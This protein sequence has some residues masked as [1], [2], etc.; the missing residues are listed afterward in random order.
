MSIVASRYLRGTPRLFMLL[1]S[2]FCFYWT[3]G[4]RALPL[5]AAVVAASWVGGR[6]VSGRHGTHLLAVGVLLTLLPLLYAKYV[7]WL[8][9]V[10]GSG[11]WWYTTDL[12]GRAIPPGLSFVSLQALG[13]VVDV[14]RRR[15]VPSPTIVHH[16][17]FLAFF[18]QLV[19][20]PIERAGELQPQLTTPHRPTP[21]DY[22]SALKLLLWGYVMKLVLADALAGPVEQLLRLPK[23]EAPAGLLLALCMF[24]ARI[25]LDFYAYSCIAVALGGLHGVRLTMNFANPY[26][27]SS[28]AS[29]WHRW[30]VSLS[31][32]WRDYVYI[33]LG[34]RRLGWVR[35]TAA[36]L[37]VF[38]LS[39]LWH[40]AGVGFLMWGVW[41]GCGLLLE[42]AGSRWMRFSGCRIGTSAQY[43]VTKLRILVVGAVV[44]VGWIPFLA[45]GERPFP[46][47]VRRIATATSEFDGTGVHLGALLVTYRWEMLLA[48]GGV[49]LAH[50]MERWYWRRD[51]TS[52]MS[53][54]TDVALTNAFSV[55]LLLFG[56]F[57]ARSFIYFAF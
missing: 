35:E 21:A 29:F 32:W 23:T 19:A 36:V 25:Y 24:S 8:L 54:I 46:E 2:S 20:G 5:L 10:G 22:Y 14:H 44:G 28:L 9:V 53:L 39:G 4:A 42:R 52:R 48:V 49:T 17:I 1:A 6:L 15:V 30:H 38:T 34:G 7:P 55:A 40:G 51:L 47:L 41:H 45:T 31:S 37:A 11:D 16:A 3:L 33:S 13:Y 12:D 43:V 27:A 18:P 57:G 50:R 26:G 56:S